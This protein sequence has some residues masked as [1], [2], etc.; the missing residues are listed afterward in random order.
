MSLYNQLILPQGDLCYDIISLNSPNNIDDI[1][2]MDDLT[3]KGGKLHFLSNRR[4][5]RFCPDGTEV[6]STVQ[7]VM[8]KN[9]YNDEYNTSRPYDHPFNY[10]HCPCD[11]Q[12]NE[13]EL[14]IS[15]SLPT[16][17]F[18]IDLHFT[19]II[20]NHNLTINGLANVKGIKLM[21][22][23]QLKVMN[24]DRFTVYT[25]NYSIINRFESENT[26]E[27]I[28]YN[29]TNDWLVIHA[30]NTSIEVDV[31]IT[32]S[33]EDS[34]VYSIEIGN[35]RYSVTNI[36]PGSIVFIESANGTDATLVNAQIGEMKSGGGRTTPAL[37]YIDE[38]ITYN[39]LPGCMYMLIDSTPNKCLICHS[40]YINVNGN[41]T[42]DSH[43][44][45][46]TS[47]V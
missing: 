7:C 35:G 12:D 37:L 31:S 41:C 20:V 36:P 22:G 25:G 15:E 17:D 8:T 14:V 43:C 40:E 2:Q 39:L 26:Q 42:L 44:N 33:D 13:C 16:V 6:D 11:S 30:N 47:N 38:N 24:T 27:L 4:L 5:I 21:E 32:S 34:N 18:K 45:S 3:V 23:K 46:R 28:H 10:P 9:D 19:T 29:T 1:Y